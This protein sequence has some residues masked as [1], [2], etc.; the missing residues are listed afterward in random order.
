MS[1][2]IDFHYW[3]GLRYPEHFH[4]LY[5]CSSCS[6]SRTRGITLTKLFSKRLSIGWLNSMSKMQP[7]IATGNAIVLPSLIFPQLPSE[8]LEDGNQ[9]IEP[10]YLCKDF[11][12]RIS[13]YVKPF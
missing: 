12:F 4:E 6:Q 3:Q 5:A 2:M 11:L 7:K 10:A 1:S 9:R 13:D 8:I